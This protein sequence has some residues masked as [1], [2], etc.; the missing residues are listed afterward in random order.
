MLASSSMSRFLL[1]FWVIGGMK[2]S[3]AGAGTKAPSCSQ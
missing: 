1:I 3:A 2:E